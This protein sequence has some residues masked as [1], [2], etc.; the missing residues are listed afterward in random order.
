M[1]CLTLKK[2]SKVSLSSKLLIKQDRPPSPL[3]DPDVLYL[4]GIIRQNKPF[5]QYWWGGVGWGG[6]GGGWHITQRG[7][8]EERE[9][10][11]AL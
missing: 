1:K 6:E 7:R 2:A 8:R 5:L 3:S 9:G 11:S 10:F 4:Y